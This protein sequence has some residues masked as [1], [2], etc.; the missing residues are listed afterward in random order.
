MAGSSAPVDLSHEDIGDSS[1]RGIVSSLVEASRTFDVAGLRK[2]EHAYHS[3]AS[4]EEELIV[5]Y[6]AWQ[7]LFLVYFVVIDAE[8]QVLP[9]VLHESC[10]EVCHIFN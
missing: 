1:I 9:S 5:S 7:V 6:A 8:V 10:V 4:K 2:C 3:K